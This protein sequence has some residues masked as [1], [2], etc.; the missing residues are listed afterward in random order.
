M[1]KK[2]EFTDEKRVILGRTLHRIMA[3]RDFGGIKK[4]TQGGWIEKESNLS[5][6]GN[7]WVYDEALVF[8]DAKVSNNAKVWDYAKVYCDANV[9]GDARVYGDANVHGDA[10]VYGDANVY[11]NTSVYGDAKVYGNTSVYG[12]ANVYGKANVYGSVELCGTAD[13]S[14]DGDYIVFKNWWSSGRYFTW[15]LSN[16]KW[17]VGCFYGTGEELIR[18]AYKDSELSGREYERIVRY[19]GEIISEEAK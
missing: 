4:G 13:V 17:K 15:T 2:Y 10:R 3:V 18:K 9:Y 11:G 16:N 7:C 1:E 19:V 8:H 12:D 5:H 14:S 6:E